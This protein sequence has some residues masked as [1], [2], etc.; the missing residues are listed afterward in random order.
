MAHLRELMPRYSHG[1][2]E[3]LRIPAPL[4]LPP[5]DYTNPLAHFQKA[6]EWQERVRAERAARSAGDC[7]VCHTNVAEGTYFTTP[8][9][10]GVAHL[11]CAVEL[12][13]SNR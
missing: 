12:I 2:D 4:D 5:V 7:T 8:F 10:G 13:A 1:R 9:N 6:R 11:D 3:P